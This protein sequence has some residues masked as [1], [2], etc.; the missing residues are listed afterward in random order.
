MTALRIGDALLKNNILLAPMAG[1]TDMAFRILCHRE[2]CGLVTTE[3][4]S[5]KGVIYADRD[6]IWRLSCEERP[7]AL[8][9]FGH[10]LEVMV[11]AVRLIC[12][13][14]SPD[15]IDI[16]MGCPVPKV[17][18]KKEGCALMLDVPLAF[19]IMKA[20]VET[21]NRP[22][23]VKIR[24]GWDD[25]HVNAV[26]MAEAAQSAGVSAITVHGRT[27]EQFYTGKAD[28]DIIR[29]VKHSVSIPVI[30]NGD[31]ACPQDAE[32]M[33]E[34]TGCDGVMIGRAAQGNP[35]IFKRT[36][37]Y[38]ETGEL[39]PPPSA[40]DRIT[41]AL[42]H[43]C[44]EVELKGEYLAVRQM[45]KHI[46]WYIKGLRDAAL[47]RDQLNRLD[48]SSDV[49]ALLLDYLRHLEAIR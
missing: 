44:M 35:W 3:M 41:K 40:R 29:Q 25:Q 18:N 23:T 33:L 30:G 9:L 46:A 36:A 47:L 19:E 24:K 13:S 27:R 42:E 20:V 22:V 10:E 37:H 31:V 11:E 39:L 15:I 38:L 7:V 32:R 17:V 26:E 12:C 5:A 43:L 1:V 8:Q 48:S 4:I 14:V 45:R 49:K 16:N 34:Y 28:W 6:E 2:G 21:A